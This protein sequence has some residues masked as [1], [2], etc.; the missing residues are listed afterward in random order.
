MIRGKLA[1]TQDFFQSNSKEREREK[2]EEEEELKL[3]LWRSLPVLVSSVWISSLK[4]TSLTV[5]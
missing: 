3:G 2:G 4:G 5:L 1:I